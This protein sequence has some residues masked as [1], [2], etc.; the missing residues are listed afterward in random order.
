LMGSDAMLGLALQPGE[1]TVRIS[2]DDLLLAPGRYYV[3]VWMNPMIDGT[4]CD[5][6]FDYPLLSVANKGLVTHGLDRQ[7]GSVFCKAVWDVEQEIAPRARVN[8]P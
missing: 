8:A 7:W 1:R 6:I 4:P 2:V 5:A 3:E